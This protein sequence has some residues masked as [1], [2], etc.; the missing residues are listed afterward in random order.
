MPLY[1]YCIKG[2]CTWTAQWGGGTAADDPS[3]EHVLSNPG[4][5]VRGGS[6]ALHTQLYYRQKHGGNVT[7]DALTSKD[8]PLSHVVP[9]EVHGDLSPAEVVA[10]TAELDSLRQKVDDWSCDSEGCEQQ[11]VC[12]KG[13]DGP[14][15]CRECAGFNVGRAEEQEAESA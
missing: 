8:W 12:T 6:S 15:R 3:T 2:G 7:K 11:A 13:V 5:I 1:E 14:A 10:L 4:H 9:G